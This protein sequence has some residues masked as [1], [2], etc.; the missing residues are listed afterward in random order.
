MPDKNLPRRAFL[1][2]ASAALGAGA[3]AAFAPVQQAF[4]AQLN[5]LSVSAGG[6]DPFADLRQKYL[7]A[8]D[9]TYF[10]HGSIGTIPRMVQQARQGYLD[11]CETNPWLYMWSKPWDEARAHT[12]AIAAGFMGCGAD[13][14]VF[15][16]NTTEAF[17]LLA[18]GLDLQ[19]GDE[20]VFSSM[21]HSGASVA[22]FHYARTRGFSVRKFDFP[23]RDVPTLTADDIV[24]LCRENLTDRTRV[25]VLP[26]IDNLV[27][28]RHPLRKIADMAHSHGVEFVA[29]DGAQSVGM[30]PVNITNLGVDFY[31]T[32]AHKWLQ[33][34]KGVG[35]LYMR[36][37]AQ[38]SVRPIWVTWGQ[39]SWAGSVQ[40]FEDYGTRNL[41]EVL[42]LS[43]AI[44][45]QKRLETQGAVQRKRALRDYV[46]QAVASR[47]NLTW[48]SPT[49]WD[50]ASSLYS[51]GL[52]GRDSREVSRDMF[53]NHGYV[54]RPF[55]GDD[56]NTLRL[57][58]NV[59]N[60]EKEIDRFFELLG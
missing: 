7:L 36:K 23:I 54:F 15:T 37:R 19:A 58:L 33:A 27:G 46:R 21:N 49:E 57:S 20:V 11:L 41:A 30:I 1:I 39:K 24:A 6:S 13:E 52:Q 43:D 28:L 55:H 42:T 45:F 47:P 16:H 26:H 59:F 29:V 3:L 44:A 12:R 34:P 60:T 10:N 32:S 40:I 31:A 8:P 38:A 4:A 53:Q 25:L 2:Q 56:W 17:S 22:W 5:N 35:L 18:G 51:I 48:R 50:L 14:V 9:V